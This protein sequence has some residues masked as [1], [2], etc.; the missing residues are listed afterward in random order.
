MKPEKV[1]VLIGKKRTELIN[2]IRLANGDW[3]RYTY[4]WNVNYAVSATLE[5]GEKYEDVLAFLSRDLK[6]QVNESFPGDTVAEP[7]VQLVLVK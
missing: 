4:S 5:P 3:K 1:N 6:R 2:P 7:K